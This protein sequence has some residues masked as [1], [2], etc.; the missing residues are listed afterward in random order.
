MQLAT[1][2]DNAAGLI[3]EGAFT[4][5]PDV[6][7]S[8][9]WGWLPVGPFITQRFDAAERIRRVRAPVLVVHGSADRLIRPELGRALYERA[10]EPKRFVLVEGGSHHNTNWVGQPAYRQALAEMFGLPTLR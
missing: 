7:A 9:E 6:F 4:S 1:E 2:V 5:I 3:V 8:F 10:P